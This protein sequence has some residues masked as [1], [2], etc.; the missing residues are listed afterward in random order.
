LCSVK[1]T[2]VPGSYTSAAA[3]T[4]SCKLEL[5]GTGYGAS[6]QWVFNCGGALATAAASSVEI[7]G[8]NAATGTVTWTIGGA[9]AT[10][11][12]SKIIGDLTAVGAITFAADTTWDGDLTSPAAAVTLGAGA[13]TGTI[14]TNGAITLG[15]NAVTNFLMN[16]AGAVTLGAGATSNDITTTGAKTLGAS[17]QEGIAPTVPDPTLT[18]TRTLTKSAFPAGKNR[19]ELETFRSFLLSETAVATSF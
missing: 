9:V 12:G 2:L 13:R 4:L 3:C 11:A 5:D 18:F 7:I 15:A 16:T 10:G 19:C 17:A 6:N 1:D 14:T 8:A